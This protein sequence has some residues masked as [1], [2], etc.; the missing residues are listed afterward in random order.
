MRKRAGEASCWLSR[1]SEDVRTVLEVGLEEAIDDD[2]EV[3]LVQTG[4]ER[5]AVWFELVWSEVL[6]VVV[7]YRGDGVVW[8]WY[9]AVWLRVSLFCWISVLFES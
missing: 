1:T 3:W 9:C 7:I 2:F 4:G 8:R 6:V 5:P